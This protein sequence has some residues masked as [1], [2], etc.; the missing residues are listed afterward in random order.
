MPI[1]EMDQC[2]PTK[3]AH[4]ARMYRLTIEFFGERLIMLYNSGAGTPT[5]TTLVEDMRRSRVLRV[6]RDVPSSHSLSFYL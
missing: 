5:K 4:G 1:P 2:A 6:L 3:S